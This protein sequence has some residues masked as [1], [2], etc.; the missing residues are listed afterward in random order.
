M[1][2]SAV[3]SIKFKLIYLKNHILLEE[4]GKIAYVKEALEIIAGLPSSTEREV[5]LR[6]IASE[7]ELSYDSLKQDCNLLRASM[8]K[9]PRRG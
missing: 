9:Q 5:Y 8:Q 2:D 6:E 4:D 7:L 1:I 3:S